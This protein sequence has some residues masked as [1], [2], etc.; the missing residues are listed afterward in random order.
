MST[1]RVQPL[2]SSFGVKVIPKSV[3]SMLR[4]RS[5]EPWS[6]ILPNNTL[7]QDERQALCLPVSP[8][9]YP[10]LRLV[11]ESRLEAVFKRSML[12][13]LDVPC[14]QHQRPR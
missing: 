13:W 4:T 12:A 11:S 10:T 5:P 3:V 14:C 8:L 6:H 1:A 7:S 2:S 9:T